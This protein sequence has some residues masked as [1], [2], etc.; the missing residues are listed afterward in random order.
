[1][2]RIIKQL[3]RRRELAWI[4]EEIELDEFTGSFYQGVV[5]N[6]VKTGSAKNA[7]IYE[8]DNKQYLRFVRKKGQGR[9]RRWRLF[10]R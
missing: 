1:M 2:K 7:E 5:S 9:V 10:S 4:P 8:R 3:K 6:M